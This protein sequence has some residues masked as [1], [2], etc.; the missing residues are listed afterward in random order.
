M[1]PHHQWSAGE[2][3]AGLSLARL[4]DHRLNAVIRGTVDPELFVTVLEILEETITATSESEPC[5][6]FLVAEEIPQCI[7]SI[8]EARRV[9]REDIDERVTE[10]EEK[11]A[12]LEERHKGAHRDHSEEMDELRKRL[13]LAERERDELRVQVDQFG[14][15]LATMRATKPLRKRG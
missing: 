14:R 5:D 6:D 15:M 8:E 13:D 3:A 4:R 9:A 10:V 1:R 12:V 2:R 11:Y 7:R